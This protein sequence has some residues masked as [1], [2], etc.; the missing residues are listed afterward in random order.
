MGAD[1]PVVVTASYRP[2]NMQITIT[3]LGDPGG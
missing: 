2:S 3:V 1:L